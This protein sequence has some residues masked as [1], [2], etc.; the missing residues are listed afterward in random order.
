MGGWIIHDV[1]DR[2]H[3]LHRCCLHTGLQDKTLASPWRSTITSIDIYFGRPI[4][5]GNHISSMAAALCEAKAH[6]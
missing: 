5:G 1:S 3:L 2:K 4:I 6:G